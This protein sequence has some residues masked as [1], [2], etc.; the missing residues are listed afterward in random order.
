M[1]SN[2]LNSDDFYSHNN[3]Q[4]NVDLPWNNHQN[5][6]SFSLNKRSHNSI[7][8]NTTIKTNNLNINLSPIE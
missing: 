5:T 4:E 3:S 2:Q 8:F 6:Q 7:Y 1:D